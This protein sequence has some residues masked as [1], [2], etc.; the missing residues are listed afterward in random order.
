MIFCY[1][2]ILQKKIGS[3][4]KPTVPKYV[5]DPL[6]RLEDIVK[7]VCTVELKPIVVL[8]QLYAYLA[9]GQIGGYLFWHLRSLFLARDQG[10]PDPVKAS[11]G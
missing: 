11:Q 5:S 3:G 8:R 1:K 9:E 6:S 10:K 7:K 4:L 2:C